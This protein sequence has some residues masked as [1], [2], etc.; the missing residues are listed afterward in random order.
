MPVHPDL[1]AELAVA[2]RYDAAQPGANLG[3]AIGSRGAR[4]READA[5]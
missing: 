3:Y 1:L 4:F 2:V 5:C